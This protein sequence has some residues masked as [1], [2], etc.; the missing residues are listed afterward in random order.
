MF[1]ALGGRAAP[2]AF[3]LNTMWEG[4]EHDDENIAW[5]RGATDAL[6]PWISPGMA[7]NFYTEVGEGEIRD[8][9]G[10]RL[11]RLRK[12]KQMYDAS[13]LFRLNQNITPA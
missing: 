9:F 2:F 3:H 4:E 10:A 6:S 8:S 12:V 1:T 7:L 11:D 5:T 13:N